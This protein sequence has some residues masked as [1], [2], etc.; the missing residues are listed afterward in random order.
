MKTTRTLLI[1]AIGV[2]MMTPLLLADLEIG[3][4]LRITPSPRADLEVYV[5]PD[6]GMDGVYYPGENINVN[7]EV[8]RDAFLV[9]Y[10][11]DSRGHM[12]ILFPSA[13]WEDNFVQAGD[14]ISFPRGYD[15]YDWTIEG[16]AGTEYIQAI[17]SEIPISLPEW[18]VY[19]QSVNSSSYIA[20]ELRNFRSDGDRY[21]Y[22]DVVNR[23]ITGRYYDWC[24]TDV[25]TFQVRSVP[26]YQHSYDYD[27]WPD[28][29]YGSVYIGWPI[30]SRIYVDNIYIGVAPCYI[31]R[32]YTGRR[33]I[34]C[35]DG[36]RLIRR[37]EFNCFSKRDYYSNNH[38]GDSRGHVYKKGRWDANDHFRYEK[39]SAKKN[40]Y[41][42]Y[43]RDDDRWDD[44]DRGRSK[45]TTRG[46]YG[47]DDD[48][49]DRGSRV[50]GDDDDRRN[51]GSDNSNGKAV[52]GR[53]K[54]ADDNN[55]SNFKIVKPST[56]SADVKNSSKSDA[57]KV[58]RS[59]SNGASN[60]KI[61]KQPTTSSADVK[62]SAKSSAGSVKRSESNGAS[63]FKIM[64]QPTTSSADVKSSA[65]SS[66]GSVK[67]SEGNSNANSKIAKQPT[68]AS[69]DVRSSAKSGSGNVK[70][71]EGNSNANYKIA[72]QPT[73]SSAGNVQRSDAGAK[74]SSQAEV[75]NAKR[76]S[77]SGK[78][79]VAE[80]GKSDAANAKSAGKSGKSSSA[81]RSKGGN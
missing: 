20:P 70:R 40:R 4:Q 66:A 34:T 55:N 61:M 80:A 13:P 59:E 67:R 38:F 50:K 41:L 72:K 77:S 73:T 45:S 14:V 1:A 5:W 64:K 81:K 3:A 62:S 30:G 49:D 6:R 8:T 25:A 44:D 52:P 63:N 42:V 33:V 12:R 10:N 39:D 60:F 2:L 22:I 28:V 26:R 56:K 36:Q 27:P 54:R 68:N 32:H 7:V 75:S 47:D 37:H 9:L 78:V 24:A 71:S 19:L 51:Y 57:G 43:D 29:F 17:A 31:P 65:K 21:H 79:K 48:N 58:K 53:E 46:G 23:N 76:S 69:A 18:P 35:Y 74:K 11:I 16:P 15:D